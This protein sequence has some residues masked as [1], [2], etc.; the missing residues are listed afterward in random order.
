ML[1]LSL[2][3]IALTHPVFEPAPPVTREGPTMARPDW[4]FALPNAMEGSPLPPA[5]RF[6]AALDRKDCP[7]DDLVDS[8]ANPFESGQD[9]WD[10]TDP[11]EE[12]A[13]AMAVF[14]ANAFQAELDGLVRP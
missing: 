3:A 12:A 10:A 13:E 8:L 14:A 1:T 5:S 4:A 9:P 2:L 11:A 7:F 6:L